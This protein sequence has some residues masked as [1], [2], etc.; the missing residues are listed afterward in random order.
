MSSHALY[1]MPSQ[2]S[3][4][5]EVED[6]EPGPGTYD[7]PT[8][9]GHQLLSGKE[10]F[11]QTSLMAKH[12]KSWAK[13][14]ISKDHLSS[15]KARDT[16]GPG[17]Y[18]PQL[19]N[20]HARVRFGSGKRPSFH[21]NTFRSPGAVY[22]VCG[23]PENTKANIRFGK[24]QRFHQESALADTGPGQYENK[25][26]FDGANLAKSFGASHRAYDRVRFPGSERMNIGMA[27]PGPGTAKP[28]NNDGH[29]PSFSKAERL[30]K[31]EGRRA[32]GPGAYEN[33]E[34]PYPFSRN[35]SC[36]SFGRPPAKGR[37]NWKQMGMFQNSVWGMQ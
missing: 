21:D 4:Y 34:R 3:Q 28:F 36:Y 19:L 9:L 20:S 22:D 16:P 1:Q 17:T 32:P 25:T 8:S 27:S 33:H 11:R 29:A 14:M 12:D 13:V 10:S 23:D 15:L 5:I 31:P 24:A 26:V 37:M 7:V 2:S 35:Q 6:L 18:Q 30:P